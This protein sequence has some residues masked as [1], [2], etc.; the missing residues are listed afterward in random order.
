MSQKKTNTI[1]NLEVARALIDKPQKWSAAW[2]N[3]NSSCDGPRRSIYDAIYCATQ[4]SSTPTSEFRALG[5]AA[6]GYHSVDALL[7][8]DRDHRHKELMG[9]FDRAI[10]ILEE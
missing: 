8:F 3:G 4:I 7:A 10:K 5:K 9:V 2:G 6:N 1:Q